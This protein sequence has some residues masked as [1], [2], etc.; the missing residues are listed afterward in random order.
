MQDAMERFLGTQEIKA[1]S[2]NRQDYNDYRGWKLPT[3]EDGADE[4][5]LVE[6]TDGGKPNHHNHAGYITWKAKE[7]FEHI[8]N[9][10][11]D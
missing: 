6:Y 1:I 10:R 9:K 2:M 11:I 3:D 7:L 8:Y 4:G 5:Y